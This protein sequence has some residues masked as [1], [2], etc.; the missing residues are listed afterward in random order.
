M[1]GAEAP[2]VCPWVCDG[3][4][5]PA[6]VWDWDFE[7]SWHTQNGQM[8]YAFVCTN[9]SIDIERLSSDDVESRLN[10][11]LQPYM[12]NGFAVFFLEG[13]MLAPPLCLA[14]LLLS[15]RGRRGRLEAEERRLEALLA[16][17]P[18]ELAG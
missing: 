4:R 3:C 9:P 10:E 6:R 13:A 11:E 8:G 2:L 1:L 15:A 17:P 16:N 12:L 7:G 14:W 18:D 5:A